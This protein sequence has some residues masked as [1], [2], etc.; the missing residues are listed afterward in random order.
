[1]GSKAA[2]LSGVTCLVSNVLVTVDGSENSIRGLDFALEFAEKYSANLSV[3]NVTE[4][5]AAAAYV[6][7]SMVAVARDLRKF[8]EEILAKAATHA[9]NTHPSVQVTTILREGDPASE[10][11]SAATEGNFDVVVVG[12]RGLG[13]V[14][15]MLLGSISDKVSRHLVCTVILVR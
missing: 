9:K 15:G 1:M 4:S 11:I 13:K 3:I 10:I 5:A 8:H 14:K 2:L 12:H 6:G 7:D